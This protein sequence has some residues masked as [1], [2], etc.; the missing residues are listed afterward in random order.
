VSSALGGL[1]LDR[2]H[3]GV[4]RLSSDPQGQAPARLLDS[5]AVGAEQGEDAALVAAVGLLRLDL[6]DLELATVGDGDGR[7][8]L[9]GLPVVADCGG[10]LGFSFTWASDLPL[11]DVFSRQ[12]D[13]TRRRVEG[14]SGVKFWAKKSQKVGFF[15]QK[16]GFRP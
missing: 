5:L 10:H 14:K 3:V 13:Y 9:I 15:G 16:Q 6:D 4:S 2:R 7:A 8:N 1:G 12:G 11:E